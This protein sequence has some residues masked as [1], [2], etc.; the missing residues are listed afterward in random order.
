MNKIKYDVVIQIKY[1]IMLSTLLASMSPTQLKEFSSLFNSITLSLLLFFNKC[2]LQQFIFQFQ[3]QF[4]VVP[5]I[6]EK[7]V[8]SDNEWDS[9]S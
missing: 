4:V 5:V 9:K 3:F 8:L 2:S 1:V 6:C 7:N